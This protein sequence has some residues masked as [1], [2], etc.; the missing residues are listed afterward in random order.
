MKKNDALLGLTCFL[1]LLL[2]T[3][4]SVAQTEFAIG[5]IIRD[6]QLPQHDD[7]GKLQ[8]MIRGDQ[9]MVM[10]T[11]RIRVKDL[12]ID[13]YQGEKSDMFM[14]SPESD[15]WKIEGRLTSSANVIVEHPSFVLTSEK[16]NWELEKSRGVFKEK[17]TLK[18]K[19][20]SGILSK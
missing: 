14:T 2:G 18:L 13:I 16:M 1:G 19:G 12:K 7:D 9:A 17:V 4:I 11:N 6:F 20:K 3:S 8:L 10:S 5:S 15:Y